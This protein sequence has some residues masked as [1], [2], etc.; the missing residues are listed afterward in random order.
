MKRFFSV[1][2][3]IMLLLST[4]SVVADTMY[5]PYC[6]TKTDSSYS[7]CPSCG[8]SLKGVRSGEHTADNSSGNLPCFSHTRSEL[9]T[10]LNQLYSNPEVYKN[11]PHSAFPIHFS[12]NLL[13]SNAFPSQNWP[14]EQ[15]DQFL[16]GGAYYHSWLYDMD[17]GHFIVPES[18]YSGNSSN[19]ISYFYYPI[20]SGYIGWQNEII[21]SFDNSSK[22]NL[23]SVSTH[24]SSEID[25][26]MSL[27]SNSSNRIVTFTFWSDGHI[28]YS[29]SPW[30]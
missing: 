14:G 27:S 7:Y 29:I 25:L 8:K 9:M 18:G 1:L 15:Y 28:G 6:G 12:V 30:Q 26:T 2:L 24:T 3:A 10:I 20:Q 11:K 23:F 17:L 13:Q 16:P 19:I 22:V 21:V 5:C 4:C